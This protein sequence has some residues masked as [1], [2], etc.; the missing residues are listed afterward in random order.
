MR[1]ASAAPRIYNS[2]AATSLTFRHGVSRLVIDT[3]F[4]RVRV[5]ERGYFYA[6]AAQRT[7]E[8]FGSATFVVEK[9]ADGRW[10]VLARRTGTTAIPTGMAT[11]PMPDLRDLFYSTVG[12]D[13]D[14][15]ED[16]R[17]A[18]RF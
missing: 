6:A 5:W 18:A 11:D 4:A 14:P 9:Q 3:R 7:C 8:E 13:R 12:R 15:E 1:P 10:L 2:L 17:N 16:A